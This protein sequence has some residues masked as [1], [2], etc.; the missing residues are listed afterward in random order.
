[1]SIAGV[2]FAGLVGLLSCEN[3]YQPD[4][5]I[6][7]WSLRAAPDSASFPDSVS[8]S[9]PWEDGVARLVREESSARIDLDLRLPLDQD[10]L[11]L[12]WWRMGVRQKAVWCVRSDE[13]GQLLQKREQWDSLGA[14]LLGEFWRHRDALPLNAE[15]ATSMGLRRFLASRLLA[16]DS[17][18]RPFPARIPAGIDPDSARADTWVAAC[19]SGWPMFR[20]LGSWSLSTDSVS[21]RRG[22]EALVKSGRISSSDTGGLFQSPLRVRAALAQ[23][24]V[25]QGDSSRPSGVF[26]WAA[27]LDIEAQATVRLRNFSAD[28]I[29]VAILSTPGA[30]DTSWD[31]AK[32]IQLK[33]GAN[34]AIGVDTLVV[35]LRDRKGRY[36]LESR[37]AFKILPRPH[38]V[39]ARDSIPPTIKRPIYDDSV[40]WKMTSVDVRWSVSDRSGLDSI[41]INAASVPL[42]PTGFYQYRMKLGLGVNRAVL[43]ARDSAGNFNSDTLRVFRRPDAIPP[44]AIRVPDSAKRTVPFDSVRASVLWRVS[45]NHKLASCKIGEADRIQSDPAGGWICQAVLNLAVGMNIAPLV[46]RDSFGNTTLDTIR[47]ER[48]KD[49]ASP[50][51]RPLAGMGSRAVSFDSTRVSVGWD[52]ADSYGLAFCKID[53]TDRLQSAPGGGWVCRTELVLAVGQNLATMLLQDS[54]GNWIRDTIRIERR[55]DGAFPTAKPLAGLGARN[56]A[57][58]SSRVVVGWSLDDN[59]RM[60]SCKIG[61]VEHLQVLPGGGWVCK[62]DLDLIVGSNDAF[63]QAMDSTENTIFDTIRI[64]RDKDK[65]P[66]VAVPMPGLGARSVAFDSTRVSIGWKVSDNDMVKTCNIARTTIPVLAGGICSTSVRPVVGSTWYRIELTDNVGNVHSDSVSIERLADTQPPEVRRLGSDTLRMANKDS[67]VTV[68]WIV[69]DNDGVES[70]S[71]N[72]LSFT[73]S[74]DT[75]KSTHLLLAGTNTLQLTLRDSARNKSVAQLVAIRDALPP[76]HHADSLIYYQPIPD[77]LMCVGGCDSIEISKDR[78]TWTRTDG[79]A[80]LDAAGTWYARSWPGKAESSI[81]IRQAPLTENVF[82][83][84]FTSFFLRNDSLFASGRNDV[85][86]LGRGSRSATPIL[87]P[88]Y[89]RKGVK[90]VVAGED[91]TLMLLANGDVVGAGEGPLAAWNGPVLGRDLVQVSTRSVDIAAGKDF[92]LVLDDTGK[93]WSVGAN[94]SGQLGTGDSVPRSSLSAAGARTAAIGAGWSHAVRLDSSGNVWA[95]GSNASGQLGLLSQKDNLGWRKVDSL[96]DAVYSSMGAVTLY[97]RAEGR[98]ILGLGANDH[99]QLSGAAGPIVA[100]PIDLY[101]GGDGAWAG[102]GASHVL[103]LMNGGHLKVAGSNLQGQIG[104]GAQS[105]SS[106]FQWL[107]GDDLKAA[108]GWEHSILV[109]T[110]GE[111]VGMGANAEGELG[112]GAVGQK[113]TPARILY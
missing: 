94:E 90:K 24:D 92:F 85:G 97:R 40:E 44:T 10:T 71:S 25:L 98:K 96:A 12:E 45:D 1:M 52:V 53:G 95:V 108:A 100:A 3:I 48:L 2:L 105:G 59:H 110:S 91:F 67:L 49:A 107:V 113:T 101:P 104:L 68:A 74:G 102:G 65:Q 58:D 57:F 17:V 76:V 112:Q 26:A 27:G 34:T 47:I 20:V 66:P 36:S 73:R 56:V 16:G 41:W 13:S 46:V 29:S 77:T 62:A 70:V 55:K 72:S 109:R 22:V 93:L 89:V 63:L 69:T 23:T 21:L 60:V 54:A 30:Q 106:G 87:S 99:G 61:G 42:D 51:A 4:C 81:A 35:R 103:V 19:K 64:L 32:G 50:T 84:V 8:W 37:A 75:V 80:M 78:T 31:L 43:K 7:T 33:V 38:V 18:F 88:V 86:Q 39:V 83:G 15:P 5:T 111:P 28:S 6:K 82:A 9:G 79:P 11:K 14:T